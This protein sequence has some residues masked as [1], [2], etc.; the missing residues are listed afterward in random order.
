MFR[1][2]GDPTP[3]VAQHRH[4]IRNKARHFLALH[5]MQAALD[6]NLL[7]ESIQQA[8]Q[9][10]KE[11]RA[12]MLKGQHVNFRSILQQRLELPQQQGCLCPFSREKHAVKGFFMIHCAGLHSIHI[13]RST[14]PGFFLGRYRG[15]FSSQKGFQKSKAALGCAL[16]VAQAGDG[17]DASRAGHR[18]HFHRGQVVIQHPLIQALAKGH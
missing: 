9:I 17:G 11:H 7:S 12:G 18:C 5:P 13:Q 1:Q 2:N 6:M 14:K 8:Q 4:G 10:L 15:F 16:I 3:S